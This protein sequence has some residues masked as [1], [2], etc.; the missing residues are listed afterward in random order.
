MPDP[1]AALDFDLALAHC[2]EREDLQ[3]VHEALENGGL[4]VAALIALC[5][6]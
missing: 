2:C 1:A 4:G 3:L 5:T 6:R